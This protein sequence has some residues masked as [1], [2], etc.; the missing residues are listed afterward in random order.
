MGGI[1]LIA[2]G[3][4]ALVGGLFTI[5]S[6]MRISKLENH[7]E[8]C[9]YCLIGSIIALIAVNFIAGIIGLVFYFLLKNERGRFHS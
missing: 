3:L 1:I 7:Q 4:L 5:L 6:C 2:I 8:A 9:T